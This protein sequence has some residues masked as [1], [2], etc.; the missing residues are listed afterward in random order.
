MQFT[1]SRFYRAVVLAFVA[2]ASALLAACSSCPTGQQIVIPSS[3]LSDPSLILD[4]HL[5][6]GQIV[7]V[8]ENS[9]PTTIAVTGGGR[10]TVIVNTKDGEGVQDS[11]IWAAEEK[12]RID[13]NTGARISAGPGLLGAPT[14]SNRDGS[15]PGQKGC[16]ERVATQNLE[17]LISPLG[18]TDFEIHASGLNFASRK[19]MTPLIKL[20]G[21]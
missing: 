1:S 6:D 10:V 18:G 16:T 21:Q 5:P 15:S 13:P 17:V 9:S 3:D 20:I 4:L 8:T 11:Q 12:Y 7:P 14:A 2:L 19:V